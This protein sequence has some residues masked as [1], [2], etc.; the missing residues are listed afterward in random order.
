M[1]IHQAGL[2]NFIRTFLTI[3]F[4]YYLVKFIIK[5][6]GP[7]LL[8]KAV[9]KVHKK[10]QSQYGY[11]EETIVEEGKTVIDKKDTKPNRN[12]KNIGEYIDFEEID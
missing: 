12:D 7:Y 6:L 9:D 5:L 4:I 8:K 3:L 11:K 10:A 1:T 2:I